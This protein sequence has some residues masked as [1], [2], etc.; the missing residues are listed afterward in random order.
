MA[1]LEICIRNVIAWEPDNFCVERIF[2]GYLEINRIL[3]VGDIDD[4]T[5]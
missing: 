5:N 2:F 3:C 1:Y 4:N